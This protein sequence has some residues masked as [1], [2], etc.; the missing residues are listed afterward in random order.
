MSITKQSDPSPPPTGGAGGEP[1]DGLRLLMIWEGDPT[2]RAL[3]AFIDEGSPLRIYL[4]RKNTAQQPTRY[5]RR[6]PIRHSD[7]STLYLR[8]GKVQWLQGAN[9]YVRLHT[10]NR[11]Y[12]VRTSL[13]ELEQR[14]DPRVFLRIHRSTI[15]NLARADKVLAVSP[16]ARWVVLADGTRLKVSPAHWTSLLRLLELTP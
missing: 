3:E 8:S 5:L 4:E 16:R 13:L 2:R 14:L 11:S 15:V 1:A 7:G 12:L 9:Q 6:F 10:S